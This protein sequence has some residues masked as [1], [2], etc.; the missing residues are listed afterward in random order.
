MK[1]HFVEK[2]R[3]FSEDFEHTSKDEPFPI[4]PLYF[5]G[6]FS[7]ESV[8]VQI[9]ALLIPGYE[10]TANAIAFAIL[11]L[12]MHPHVQEQ[13][14][15]ELHSVYDSQDEETTYEHIQK[16]HLLD[17]VIKETLRLF[18]PAPNIIRSTTDVVSISNCKLPKDTAVLLSVFTMHRV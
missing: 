4:I 16:L 15:E 17:R 3:V 18:P 9:E 14:F 8:K 12:S 10:T 13:V 6:K 11:A 1:A 7:E 5:E 2:S